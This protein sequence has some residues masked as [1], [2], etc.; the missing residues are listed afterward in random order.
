MTVD[1]SS[2]AE[3]FLIVGQQFKHA[4]APCSGVSELYCVCNGSTRGSH[5]TSSMTCRFSQRFAATG[6]GSRL[7]ASGGTQSLDPR[8]SG[9][10]ETLGNPQD[11]L[12]QSEILLQLGPFSERCTSSGGCTRTGGATTARRGRNGH[13]QE[14]NQHE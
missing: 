9:R 10:H 14:D 12:E 3:N 11:P 2:C 6:I 4:V 8:E 13:G 1:S 7:E 5:S